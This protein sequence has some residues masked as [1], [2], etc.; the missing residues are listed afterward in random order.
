MKTICKNCFAEYEE[1][2]GICPV[3]GYAEGDP[4]KEPYVLER[5][6]LLKGRYRIGGVIG[7]GGFGI[8][9]KARDEKLEVVVAIKEYYPSGLVNRAPGTSEVRLYALNRKKEFTHGLGRFIDEARN[10]AKFSSHR[11]IVNVYEYFEENGTAYIAMEFLDGCSLDKYLENN[12]ITLD[13]SLNIIL[14]VCS[15]LKEIHASGIIHRDISPDNIFICKNGMVKLL[16]F[17]AARFSQEEDKQ[18]TIILKPGFA[19]AEQYE[20]INKQ[21]PWTDVYALGATLY[22]MLTGEKPEESTNRKTGDTLASP[23]E[24]N[25]EIPEHIS[26]SIMKAMAVDVYLRFQTVQEFEDGLKQK[27]KVV[28]LKVEKKRRK[29]RR[30]LG[31][32]AAVLVVVGLA[33]FF[34]V[35][36][37][38]QRE[39]ETLPKADIVIWYSTTGDESLDEGRYEAYTKIV[40]L[41]TESFPEVT[42]SIETFEAEEYEQALEDALAND[43][44]PNLF[45]SDDVSE[46]ILAAACDVSSVAD[47]ED[48]AACYFLDDYEKYFPDK[49]QIPLGFTVQA[50]YVNTTLTELSDTDKITVE[51]ILALGD[52]SVEDVENYAILSSEEPAYVNLLGEDVV[53]R[54]TAS[55]EDFYSGSTICLLADTSVFRTVQVKL[56]ARYAMLYLDEDSVKGEFTTLWSMVSV[57][58]NEDKAA[59]RLLQYFLCEKAQDYLHLQSI[60]DD[61]PISEYALSELESVYPEYDGFFANIDRVTFE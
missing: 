55:E 56:P 29:R 41:F 54:I 17:G 5:G 44:M 45:L 19:P 4:V 10:M 59:K 52:E 47:T 53:S 32:I 21:G 6:M 58:K 34:F 23:H 13:E 38:E 25:P 24:L 26:N 8:M 39:E 12:S 48:A 14:A 11:N 46:S 22:F 30:N 35:N 18:L 15:A 57:S 36:W 60:S 3:C 49:N 42:V 37:N 27:K 16:D 31:V 43:T 28:E 2:M 40:D 9:Y 33:A 1:E 61:L 7:I 51:Q 50:V 20:K